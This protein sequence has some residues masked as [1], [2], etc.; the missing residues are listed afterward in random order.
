MSGPSGVE[1]GLLAAALAD[2]A[3]IDDTVDHVV[4][5]A[6]ET[7]GTRSGAITL[8][9][10]GGKRFE[11]VGATD[12]VVLEA[13]RLQYDLR[14]GP[15]VDASVESRSLASSDLAHDSRWPVWGPRASDLGFHSILSAEL[16]SRGQ[17]IGALNLYGD[18][19]VEFSEDDLGTARLFAHHAAIALAYFQSER[20]LLQAIDT[21]TLIGQAQ[22]IL[23]ERFSIGSDQAFAV[24]RR[25]SQDSN[26]KLFEVARRFVDQR[27]LPDDLAMGPA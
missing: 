15:C 20:D 18:A 10:S 13:D 14:E 6:V 2:S 9:Q 11:T 8:I 21:R 23:M 12:S 24:L 22:G 19:G 16:H 4:R 25:Y 7:L 5:F 1:L 26:T 17:R 27:E 3:T